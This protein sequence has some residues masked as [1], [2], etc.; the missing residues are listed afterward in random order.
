[1]RIP[2]KTL[3]VLWALVILVLTLLPSDQ[4]PETPDWTTISFDKVAHAGV[5]SVLMFFMTGSF[6][7][8][9]RFPYLQE[10]PVGSALVCSV[11]FGIG[12]ELLQTGMG[13]GREGSLLDVVGNTIGCFL[14]IG[15]FFL[16]RWLRLADLP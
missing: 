4:L 16:A 13:L 9:R 14:G 11:L 15:L 6:A 7:H 1:M 3:T 8:Q 10:H 2:F 12:I 5:F